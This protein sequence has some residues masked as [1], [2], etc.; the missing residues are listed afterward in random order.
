MKKES[1]AKYLFK[2]TF[3]LALGNIS[4]KFIIFLLIPLY[5]NFLTTKEYG[6]IDFLTIIGTVLVPLFFLNLYEGII[7]YSLEKKPNKDAII[8][9]TFR[10]LLF[11]IIFSFLIIPISSYINGLR[12]YSILLYLYIISFGFCQVFISFLRGNEKL[13]D[14]AISNF[15]QALLIGAFNIYFL[16]FLK[17]GITGYFLSYIIANLIVSIYAFFRSGII[18]HLKTMKFDYKLSKEIIIY[19]VILIPNS[20]MWWVMNSLDKAM[21]TYMISASAN[22]I[23]AVSYKLPTLVS[24]FSAIFNQ[25]WS[26]SAIKENDSED[27]IEFNNKGYKYLARIDL[28]IG[29]GLLMIIKPFLKIY[30]GNDFYSAWK[31]TPFL[32]V[33]FVFLT[34][35]TFIG[36]SYTVNKDS[37]GFLKSATCG[38][39]V[40]IIL[41]YLL[42]NR[43]GI[44]GAAIATCIS[45]IVVF[46]YRA[47]DTRKYLKLK[48]FDR[49]IVLGFVILIVSAGL[50]YANVIGQIILCVNFLII[51]L[52]YKETIVLFL[53]KLL[54]KTVKNK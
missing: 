38:A 32:I 14:Y 18:S 50:V 42:I 10:V 54:K 15:A 11:S 29:I 39:I 37:L 12:E 16:A 43:Y 34:L 8:A 47:I 52:I 7:R 41:N 20:L 44:I 27:K 31:Y 25:A 48:L 46:I 3:L 4:S 26:F 53:N 23:Y 13:L 2:N 35:G 21:I 33:G 40:N 5:T 24:N 1:R 19:S 45:Y 17:L 36:T 6:Q 22:G 51:I 49:N 30:V 9:L 28:I